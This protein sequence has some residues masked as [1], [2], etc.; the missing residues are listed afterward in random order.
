[1]LYILLTF[2]LRYLSILKIIQIGNLRKKERKSRD[3]NKQEQRGEL[4]VQHIWL[5]LLLHFS[6]QPNSELS[7]RQG[8]NPGMLSVKQDSV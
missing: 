2:S 4:D 6:M 3:P 7:G 1:M 5:S 8:R